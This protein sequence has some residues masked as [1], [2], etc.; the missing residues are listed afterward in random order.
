VSLSPLAEK[1]LGSVLTHHGLSPLYR[2]SQPFTVADLRGQVRSYRDGLKKSMDQIVKNRGGDLAKA[3][4]Y[5][6]WDDK[7]ARVEG[8]NYALSLSDGALAQMAVAAI[9]VG[10]FAVLAGVKRYFQDPAAQGVKQIVIGVGADAAAA[11]AA[12]ANFTA[13][14]DAPPLTRAGATAPSP[15][16]SRRGRVAVVGLAGAAILGLLLRSKG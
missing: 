2:R 15:S 8:A 10:S 11:A 1:R 7:V 6:G 4:K 13:A 16:P 9:P 5:P 12:E 3:A 14:L